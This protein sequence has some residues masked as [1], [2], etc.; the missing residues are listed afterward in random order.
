MV[1]ACVRLHDITLTSLS[2]ATI[3]ATGA[4]GVRISHNAIRLSTEHDNKNCSSNDRNIHPGQHTNQ[5]PIN[6]SI[7]DMVSYYIVIEW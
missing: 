6:Q 4:P 2:C 7:N 5:Q 3:E 1:C